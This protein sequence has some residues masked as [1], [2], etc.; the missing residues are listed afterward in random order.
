MTFNPIQCELLD[1]IVPKGSKC[2]AEETARIVLM[3]AEDAGEVEKA[4]ELLYEYFEMRN[5]DAAMGDYKTELAELPG[6]FAP[7]EGCFLLAYVGEELVGSVAYKKLKEFEGNCELKRLYVKP[8]HRGKKIGYRLIDRLIEEA[9]KAGYT[10]MKLDNHPWM[11]EA[12]SLYHAFGF[13][14]IEP[15][16]NNPTENA[17]YFELDM[18]GSV[19]E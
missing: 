2:E 6:L 11:V 17:K 4:R 3:N 9:K 12:E 8:S 16:W 1:K 13:V 7:P 15:Y 10:T 14:R 19:D 18:R 5:F